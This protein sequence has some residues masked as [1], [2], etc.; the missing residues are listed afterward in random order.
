M[1]ISADWIVQEFDSSDGSEWRAR[2]GVSD[3]LQ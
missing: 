1:R 3:V 2:M